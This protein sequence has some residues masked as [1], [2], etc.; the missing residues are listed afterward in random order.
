MKKSVKDQVRERLENSFHT[1]T[2]AAGSGWNGEFEKRYGRIDDGRIDSDSS[3]KY[4]HEDIGKRFALVKDI[5]SGGW[6]FKKGYIGI[7]RKVYPEKTSIYE[8]LEGGSK[9]IYRS[10]YRVEFSINELIG[11]EENLDRDAFEFI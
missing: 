6:L 2:V 5:N 9:T 11:R 10:V 7:V 1:N 8:Y 4:N 3:Y